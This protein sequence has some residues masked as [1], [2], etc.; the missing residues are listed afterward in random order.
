MKN[1]DDPIRADAI[2]IRDAFDIV[3]QTITPDWQILAERL[4]PASPYY[5]AFHERDDKD[6]ANR[7]A[8]RA[9]DNAQR[10]ANEWLRE[11]I[12]QGALIALVRDPSTGEV[13][14][15][16]RHEW[17]SMDDFETGITSN[18]VAPGDALQSGP[19]TSIKK[20][21]RPVFFNRK[22]FDDLV[23]QIVHPDEVGGD[24]TSSLGR[25]PNRATATSKNRPEL[26]Q[27]YWIYAN[28]FG[29]TVTRGE[30]KSAMKQFGANSSD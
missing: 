22:N 26:Q 11:R 15:L 6:R 25:K 9:F 12:G 13:L 23:K 29:Q 30:Q 19:D 3:Y 5:D 28:S 10:F 27:Q 1:A 18:F 7:E 20:K 24:N 21:R 17:A 14:Q 2:S 8:W 16:D 4:N